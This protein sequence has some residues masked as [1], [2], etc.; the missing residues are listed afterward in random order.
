MHIHKGLL[1][2]N[3]AMK[4]ESNQRRGVSRR[5]N[6]FDN[7]APTNVPND[8]DTCQTNT[9]KHN[10]G[11][12]SRDRSQWIRRD[13]THPHHKLALYHS[14]LQTTKWPLKWKGSLLCWFAEQPINN[15]SQWIKNASLSNWKATGKTHK[16]AQSKTSQSTTSLSPSRSTRLG[17]ESIPS[18]RSD[19][20]RK[21]NCVTRAIR[22]LMS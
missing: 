11:R 9:H 3:D 5:I 22:H 13:S 15:E 6:L 12:L 17:A 10:R 7:T 19:R 16:W 14:K 2:A 8:E 18:S 21:A 20:K 4:R 1:W